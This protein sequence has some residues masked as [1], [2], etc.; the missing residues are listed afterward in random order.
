MA[1]QDFSFNPF[2][3]NHAKEAWNNSKSSTPERILNSLGEASYDLF[4]QNPYDLTL[5]NCKKW[6]NSTKPLSL[7]TKI[8]VAST[9]VFGSLFTLMLYGTSIH[10]EGKA[11]LALGNKVGLPALVKVGEVFKKTGK[12]IFLMGAVPVYALL[13]AGPKSLIQSLPNIAEFAAKKVSMAAKW[14]FDHLLTPM[15]NHVI[16]PA[17]RRIEKAVTF[18]ARHVAQAM[19][20]AANVI[21]NMAQSIFKNVLIPL[22]EKALFPALKRIGEAVHF[23]G[24]KID[25]ALEAIIPKV[26]HAAQWIFQKI[27]VPLWNRV[28]FPAC[29]GIVNGLIF[30]YDHL[31]SA[32]NKVAKEVDKAAQWV[33]KHLLVPAWNRLVLPLA[34]NI[35]RRLTF[36]A[37]AIGNGLSKLGKAVSQAAAFIF[38]RIAPIFK[39]MVSALVPTG[40]FLN[41]FVIKPCALILSQVADKICNVAQAIFENVVI[42]VAQAAMTSAKAIGNSFMEIKKEISQAI[43]S[44]W[45]RFST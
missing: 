16:H 22:W 27:L 41:K 5:G 20:A 45:Q 33:F 19:K 8:A 3:F 28:L 30:L 38:E 25:S 36:V 32:I 31:S 2:A 15:W 1:I 29:H 7:T 40:N 4:F 21:S 44:I 37:K 18:I 34:I 17:A 13:Y 42:P 11:A 26:S 6:Q 43:Y 14:V 35:G 24:R 23:I 12:H 10:L 9:V 39:K